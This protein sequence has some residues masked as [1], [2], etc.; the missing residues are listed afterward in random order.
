MHDNRLDI[1]GLIE[2]QFT[3]Q[4]DIAFAR[5]HEFMIRHHPVLGSILTGNHS[6]F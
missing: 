2:N 1:D 6:F 4:V 3:L 5:H